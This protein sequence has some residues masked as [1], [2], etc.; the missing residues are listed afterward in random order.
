[1][2]RSSLIIPTSGGGGQRLI[3]AATFGLLGMSDAL[4]PSG[5][6]EEANECPERLTNVSSQ[7]DA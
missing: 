6:L 2:E 1:M 5:V 3:S 7:S 4:F